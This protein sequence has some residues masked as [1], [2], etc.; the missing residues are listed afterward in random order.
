MSS[1][2]T[3]KRS[4]PDPTSTDS[5]IKTLRVKE[6]EMS[7]PRRYRRKENKFRPST[8]KS[9]KVGN[10][11]IDA[12][13][14]LL[15]MTDAEVIEA[16]TDQIPEAATTP[17]APYDL[18]FGKSEDDFLK[19]IREAVKEMEE[20]ARVEKEAKEKERMKQAAAAA[21][22]KQK[23]LMGSI[24]STLDSDEES[25]YERQSETEED[26]K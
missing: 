3:P 5:P 9:P 8:A 7:P 14:Q 10:K 4:N 2:R 11:N 1:E 26:E 16:L 12:S 18:F 20:L 19:G 21:A 25:E 17:E 22:K 24:E 6:Y 23:D 15:E 13:R